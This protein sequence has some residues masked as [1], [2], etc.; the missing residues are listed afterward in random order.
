[1]LCW[2]QGYGL[3]LSEVISVSVTQI[4]QE[5]PKGPALD[6]PWSEWG[7]SMDMLCEPKPTK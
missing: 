1:M 3:A 4:P 5:T 6:H 2:F 7:A